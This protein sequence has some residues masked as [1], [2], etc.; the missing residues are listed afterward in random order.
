VE[1]ET[2]ELWVSMPSGLGGA[3]HKERCL[4]STEVKRTGKTDGLWTGRPGWSQR[5]QHPR[6]HHH[7]HRHRHHSVGHALPASTSNREAGG[8]AAGT[9]VS[10]QYAS[11]RHP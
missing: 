5:Q 8:S 9:I 7:R 4:A 2:T 3:E 1:L 6:R 11:A 10:V